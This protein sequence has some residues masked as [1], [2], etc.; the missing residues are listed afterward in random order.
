[1]DANDAPPIALAAG[2]APSGDCPALPDGAR[3][4]RRIVGARRGAPSASADAPAGVTTPPDIDIEPAPAPDVAAAFDT[5][6]ADARAG[7]HRATDAAAT[8]SEPQLAARDTE[9]WLLARRAQGAALRLDFELRTALAR[10]VFRRDFVY[11]SRQLHALEA[12]RRVQGLDRARLDG[13]LAALRQRTDEV[14]AF[15]ERQAAE[16]QSAIAA[17]GPAG[18]SIAF[19]RPARFQATI[20]SPGAHRFLTLLMQADETLARLEMA[21]LLGLVDPA[22]RSALV[23]DCRRRL[24]GFKDLASGQRRAMGLLVQEANAQQREGFAMPP[25]V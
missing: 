16:L 23:G 20:V 11:V 12:S 6:S 8:P 17:R 15:L 24:L 10:Q 7:D 19:A 13:A 2:L 22:R 21:W 3:W 9:L 18:A 4:R 5:P 1:M 14:Q 25:V